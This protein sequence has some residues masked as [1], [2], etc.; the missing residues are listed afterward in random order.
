MKKKKPQSKKKYNS[1][2]ALRQFVTEEESDL[3]E[4]YFNAAP[5][6]ALRLKMVEM[7]QAKLED[8]YAK[9]EKVGKYEMPSWSE[10][11]ADAIGYRRALRDQIAFLIGQTNA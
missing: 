4:E 6:K 11:Q 2:S 9:T 10:Y 5:T 3:Y 8:S 1:P 7:F